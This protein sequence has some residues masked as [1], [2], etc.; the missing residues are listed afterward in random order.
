M[1]DLTAHA[2]YHAQRQKWRCIWC[3]FHM[4]RDRTSAHQIITMEIPAGVVL[5]SRQRKIAV[6]N[7]LLSFEHVV[8]RALGGSN[9]RRNGLAA[10]RWCNNWRGIEEPEVFKRRV[11]ALVAAGTHPRQILRKEGWW[12]PRFPEKH[13]VL[14]AAK[15]LA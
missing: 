10:C 8:P 15:E 4:A 7:I 6:N 14:E 13:P 1:T 11:M 5:T 12:S 2:R 9:M 3:E